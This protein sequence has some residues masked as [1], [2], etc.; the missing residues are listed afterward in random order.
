MNDELDR[1]LDFVEEQIQH[2][3]ERIKYFTK[4]LNDAPRMLEKLRSELIE[5]E[6]RH[7]DL[8]QKYYK[9]A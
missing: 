2:R 1:E 4:M 8:T 3:L 7:R 9:E 6:T 5:L